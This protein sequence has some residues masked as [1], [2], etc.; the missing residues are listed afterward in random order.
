[1][2]IKLIVRGI[3]SLVCGVKDIS[4]NIVGVSIVDKYLE[5][6]RIFVF[7]NGGDEKYYISSADWMTRNLDHRCEV[8]VHIRDKHVQKTLKNILQIQLSGNTKARILDQTLSNKYKR[9][10]ANEK[11][12][13]AQDEVYN[14]LLNENKQFQVQ[15]HKHIAAN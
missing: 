6:M 8:A 4:E 5:H 11:Q 10:K 2:K 9:P 15:T 3:C 12:V 7:A 1:M 14:Y 13:R